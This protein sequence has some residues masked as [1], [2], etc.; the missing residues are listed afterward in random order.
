M[1]AFAAVYG[2]M[3]HKKVQRVKVQVEQS[4]DVYKR[5]NWNTQL[6]Q[7][8]LGILGRMGA[9]RSMVNPVFSICSSSTRRLLSAA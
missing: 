6:S 3:E 2:I 1:L 4:I 9:N 5:Q 8:L 7:H